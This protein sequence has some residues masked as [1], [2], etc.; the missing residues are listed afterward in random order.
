MNT[1]WVSRPLAYDMPSNEELFGEYNK[2]DID[3][4]F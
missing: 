2:A 1:T 3:E 4:E